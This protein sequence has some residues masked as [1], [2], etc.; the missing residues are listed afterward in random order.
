[1][2]F[3]SCSQLN[4]ALYIQLNHVSNI[5]LHVKMFLTRSISCCFHVKGPHLI[6]GIGPGYVPFFED[7]DKI[8]EIIQVSLKTHIVDNFLLNIMR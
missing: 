1:M 6:Q 5:L 2:S 4:F 7:I 3:R 8:D